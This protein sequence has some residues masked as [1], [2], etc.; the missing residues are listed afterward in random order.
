MEEKKRKQIEAKLREMIVSADQP[1][2]ENR[3]F[4][5]KPL[6]A[7]VIRRRKGTGDLKIR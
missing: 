1:T 6:G 7:T 4:R 2:K 5:N 3:P